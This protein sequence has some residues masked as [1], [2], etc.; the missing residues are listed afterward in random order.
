M[1][2]TVKYAIPYPAPTA[3]ATIPK[4]LQDMATGVEGGVEQ[5]IVNRDNFIANIGTQTTTA[6]SVQTQF[7]SISARLTALGV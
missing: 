3:P 1:P 2:T 7:N 6:N 4:Y 5:I